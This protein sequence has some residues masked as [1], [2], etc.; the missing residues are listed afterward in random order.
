[1]PSIAETQKKYFEASMSSIDQLLSKYRDVSETQREK[2]TYFERL[3]VAFLSSDPVQSEEF[4]KIWTWQE[5][6]PENGSNA[7][8]TGIDLV[9]KLRNED[10]FAAIQAKFYAP[11]TRIQKTHIDSFI[12]ASGKAPLPKLDIDA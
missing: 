1:M 7:K 5:W 6:A 11:E 9:A 2:G 4:E 8:D 10:G 12:S 3:A